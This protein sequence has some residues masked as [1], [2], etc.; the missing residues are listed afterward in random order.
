MS[1]ELAEAFLRGRAAQQDYR[2][3]K[4]QQQQLMIG[5]DT[6]DAGRANALFDSLNQY[7]LH[8]DRSLSLEDRND[9]L[10]QAVK[11]SPALGNRTRLQILPDGRYAIKNRF[12]ITKKI[13]NNEADMRQ[14]LRASHSQY[15][16]GA[17][18]N[19]QL[20]RDVRSNTPQPPAKPP[21]T[22]GVIA[23][24]EPITRTEYK[25][26]SS[27]STEEPPDSG[28]PKLMLQMN[29]AIPSL[30]EGRKQQ[31]AL[32][33][34]MKQ[35]LETEQN[36]AIRRIY[37]G[38]IAMSQ[39]EL[40]NKGLTKSEQEKKTKALNIIEKSLEKALEARNKGVDVSQSL[41]DGHLARVD[42]LKRELNPSRYKPYYTPDLQGLIDKR[43]NTQENLNRGISRR[44]L[45]GTSDELI[46]NENWIAEQQVR[47][48]SINN[49][50]KEHADRQEANAKIDEVEQQVD[51]I[52]FNADKVNSAAKGQP[53]DGTPERPDTS[54]VRDQID[55]ART[56]LNPEPAINANNFSLE[57]AMGMPKIQA[58]SFIAYPDSRMGQSKDVRAAWASAWLNTG[59]FGESPFEMMN[60]L[61]SFID[62][63]KLPTSL[64]DRIAALESYAKVAESVAKI[65][66]SYGLTVTPPLTPEQ[67]L[68][69]EKNNF[70][71]LTEVRKEMAPSILDS[72]RY[73]MEDD[74]EEAPDGLTQN[75]EAIIQ[76][77]MAQTF[78]DVLYMTGISQNPLMNK[79][80][81]GRLVQ[82]SSIPGLIPLT[83]AF[84]MENQNESSGAWWRGVNGREDLINAAGREG[85]VR[86][87]YNDDPMH[88][89][90]AIISPTH[91]KR[92]HKQV[93]AAARLA[94]TIEAF[95]GLSP[96][97]TGDRA[98][99]KAN[100]I[101]IV[102][103]MNGKEY[104]MDIRKVFTRYPE[105]RKW[106]TP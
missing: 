14:F 31:L 41:I 55:Q 13:F 20:I 8:P 45:P 49:Q 50:I 62:T 48:E 17:M 104:G 61:Q 106:M 64:Q 95:H 105:I 100:I 83:V 90:L 35:R 26:P 51:E 63:G 65:R 88:R 15:G 6:V 59:A 101:D 72:A 87:W 12:G 77:P 79:A 57:T 76:G 43:D 92:F 39:K 27:D 7:D 98:K 86:W 24:H 32:I 74:F 22:V 102:K 60:K 21:V 19:A 29:A 1:K 2:A 37:E 78:N 30:S 25:G 33:K 42:K 80:S 70:E 103:A 38:Q 52:D 94:R 67:R 47:L 68:E 66:E 82:A 56:E 84:S 10:R 53:G 23:P 9:L 11:A 40:K 71:Y 16:L 99:L 4:L 46:A 69:L 36:P 54:A 97:N 89:A 44:E 81:A 85:I 3:R 28:Q 18:S 58:Y 5:R 91:N 73:I 96:D 75:V 93:A 34:I